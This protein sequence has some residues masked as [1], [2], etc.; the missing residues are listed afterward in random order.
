VTNQNVAAPGNLRQPRAQLIRGLLGGFAG[1]HRTAVKDKV[2]Q[3]KLRE[4]IANH[5]MLVGKV[6]ST[7]RYIRIIPV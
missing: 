1:S 3:L 5:S 4:A 6:P 7:H 2:A